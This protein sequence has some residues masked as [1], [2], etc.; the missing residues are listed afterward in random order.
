MNNFKKEILKKE[1][2]SKILVGKIPNIFEEYNQ[3]YIN[4]FNEIDNNSEL[5]IFFNKNKNLIEYNTDFYKN[6]LFKIKQVLINIYKEFR[7]I[8]EDFEYFID[9]F[10]EDFCSLNSLLLIEKNK[11]I[12]KQ[13]NENEN[14]FINDISFGIF[15][16]EESCSRKIMNSIFNNNFTD[17]FYN[18]DRKLRYLIDNFYSYL[19]IKSEQI[20]Y[21]LYRLFNNEDNEKFKPFLMEKY[22]FFIDNNIFNINNLLFSK[23]KFEE[24]NTIWIYYKHQTILEEKISKKIYKKK[25]IYES[26]SCIKNIY[27]SLISILDFNILIDKIYYYN[28]EIDGIL[29]PLGLTGWE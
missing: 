14:A 10:N 24:L 29:N 17:E 2:I 7:I 3:K 1:N 26:I 22:Y 4:D 13:K 23:E 11:S 5:Y 9:K 27:N 18:L 15:S 19:Y 25:D 12:N 28:E 20:L 16:Y 8:N 21:F 6:F